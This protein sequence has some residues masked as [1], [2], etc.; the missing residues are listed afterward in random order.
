MRTIQATHAGVGSVLL[1]PT[2][3]CNANCS[4]CSSSR[5]DSPRW[6][7]DTWRRVFDWL[8]PVLRSGAD[9][10]WHGGEPMLLGAAFYREAVAYTQLARPDVRHSMQ[11]NLLAYDSDWR[12]VLCELFGGQV[13]SSFEPGTQARRLG[14]SAEA[15]RERFSRRLEQA[16]E[17][18]LRPTLVCTVGDDTVDAAHRLY[19][20]NLRRGERS[21]PLRVNYLH[22][23]GRLRGQGLPMQ[24]EAYGALLC[25]LFDRM[26]QD[27]PRFP[28]RPVVDMLLQLVDDNRGACPWTR[29]CTGSVL[30]ITPDLEIHNCAGFGDLGA[31]F[32]F[33]NIA[34]VSARDAL[35]S[36][37]ARRLRRASARLPDAC[38]ACDYLPQCRGGCM[39]HG[40]LVSGEIEGLFSHCAA[41]KALYRHMDHAI[42]DGRADNLL[43]SLG[44]PVRGPET[45]T[46]T[47]RVT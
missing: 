15:Y 32:S 7:L 43:R 24:P 27:V 42:T 31:E 5:S 11:T 20:E 13:S 26:C 23:S 46:S 45:C 35:V 39:L 25:E 3:H 8:A 44:A 4:Y 19:L 29:R 2:L 9:L 14:R 6:G 18:G 47:A 38:N 30:H 33:G 34:T 10:I 16:L 17:D 36:M 12:D 41:W 22:A 28:V 40:Y 21:V 37:A 1:H